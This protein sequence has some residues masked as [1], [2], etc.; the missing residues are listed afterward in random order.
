VSEQT[1]ALDEAI[2]TLENEDRLS[3]E[4]LL[5]R[6]GG[7]EQILMEHFAAAS[8]IVIEGDALRSRVQELERRFDEAADLTDTWQDLLVVFEGGWPGSVLDQVS[9]AEGRKL[10]LSKLRYLL[11][12]EL[13]HIRHFEARM[14]TGLFKDIERL[15]E[16]AR[17]ADAALQLANMK[18]LATGAFVLAL[19]GLSG[20][21]A[22]IWTRRVRRKIH[23]RK[24][25]ELSGMDGLEQ[26]LTMIKEE[27]EKF[28]LRLHAISL[29][30]ARGIKRVEELDQLRSTAELIAA[31]PERIERRI[32]SAL[33]ATAFNA[34]R[35]IARGA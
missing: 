19:A 35:R 4:S 2:A 26:L 18:R 13:S 22:H 31:R 29:I 9:D 12:E 34:E 24:T 3:T 14:E 21:L 8:E 30:D 20:F 6:V 33:H 17:R 7:T 16:G 5:H 23:L 10:P 28:Y 15:D 11:T 1:R 32:L 27:K 25:S